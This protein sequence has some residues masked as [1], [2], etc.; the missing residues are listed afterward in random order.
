M[1]KMQKLNG[2]EFFE[3]VAQIIEQ[4]RR[5]VGRTADLTKCITNYEIGRM[6]VEEEQG[7]KARAAYGKR[8]LAGLSEYLNNRVGRGFSETTLKYARL[9]YKL[10]SPSISQALPDESEGNDRPQIRQA[11]L[12]E[13]GNGPANKKSQA[14][15]SQLYPFTLSWSHYLVLMRIKNDDERRF[16]E[17]EATN[18][19]WSY[20]FMEE[21]FSKSLYERLALSRDKGA[22]MR[23]AKEG[24]TIEK[25]KDLLKNP[26][27]LEFLGLADKAVYDE[28]DLETAILSKLQDFLLELGKGFLFEARQKR[29]TFNEKHYKL[30]LVC[31]NRLLK[32]YVLI[33]LKTDTLEHKDLG[34]MLM[35]VHYFDRHVKTEDEH[36]T[37]GILLCKEKDDAIV[38]LTLPEGE[39]IYASEYSLYLP[40]K[41][42][43]QRK[44][45]EWIEEF[46]EAKALR[47]LVLGG[48]V[49]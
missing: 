24:Q 11:L 30:D 31:Y 47:E 27:T 14:M 20:R 2:F 38:E 12:G 19:N 1:D 45:A 21:Q 39:N 37:V 3:N 22:V 48:D 15:I 49:E 8:L 43:L 4:A 17:I 16:Y 33:D 18:Q 40:D 42:L 35:Y 6:I 29:F 41:M 23:L 25:P 9:F 34:Q 7:G 32:C 13:F 10:Y 44:L 26:L 28:N 36:P 5:H 46:E